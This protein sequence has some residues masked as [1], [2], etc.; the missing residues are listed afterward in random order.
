MKMR[1]RGDTEHGY[2]YFADVISIDYSKPYIHRTHYAYLFNPP[3]FDYAPPNPKEDLLL[4][5]VRDPVESAI[6]TYMH[7][8]DK[9]YSWMM[10]ELSKKGY[11][12]L[13]DALQFFDSW[14]SE[15]RL[16]IYYEDQMLY[17]RE[18][19]EKIVCF[20]GE[21][22]DNVDE[23]IENIDHHRA[24]T[25][26]LYDKPMSQGKDLTYHARSLSKRQVKQLRA[27]IEASMPLLWERYLSRYEMNN[28]GIQ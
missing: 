25:L 8:G 14:P 24:T 28:K 19:I 20:I 9:P 23:F 2:R 12:A 18:M 10:S 5:L 4:V 22:T 26:A 7:E 27:T 1:K 13:E 16:L 11:E 17:P 15:R 6:R 21:S 3:Y